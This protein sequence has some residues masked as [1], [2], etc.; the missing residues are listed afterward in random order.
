MKRILIKI[1]LVE[2]KELSK[3]VMISNILIFPAKGGYEFYYEQNDELHKL[4]IK[5]VEV[6][7]VA[8]LD[9]QAQLLLENKLSK[10]N[11]TVSSISH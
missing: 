8:E 2:D 1:E 5:N 10:V 7:E 6:T 9:S 3:P 4:H 11:K